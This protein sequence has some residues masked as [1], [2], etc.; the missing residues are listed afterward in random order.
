MREKFERFMIGRCGIDQ[1]NRF[2]SIFSLVVMIA[3]VIFNGTRA[4]RILWIVAFV[5]VVIVYARM[6]SRNLYR[7]SVENTQY[8]KFKMSISGKLEMI[9]VR[10]K[11]RKESKFFSCPSCHTTLRVPRH[12]GKINIVCKKCGTSFRGK[13]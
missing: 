2:L 11:Q 13:T 9:R 6:L 8:L 1:L 4:S 3:A 7:R 5:L 12:K 10:W